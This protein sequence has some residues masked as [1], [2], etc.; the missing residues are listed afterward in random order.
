MKCFTRLPVLL[1]RGQRLLFRSHN[2]IAVKIAQPMSETKMAKTVPV[3]Y[4]SKVDPSSATV[5]NHNDHTENIFTEGLVKI[6]LRSPTGTF[7]NP[8][9]EF[10]RDLTLVFL[11]S[12][13]V[14]LLS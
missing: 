14:I 6:Q 7:Y 4:N 8:V 5:E 3:S 12:K 9:Q 2:L 13:S 1:Q 11:D 10:N